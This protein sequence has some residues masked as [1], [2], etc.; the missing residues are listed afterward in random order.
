MSENDFDV[1]RQRAQDERDDLVLTGEEIELPG[2]DSD[3]SAIIGE[4]S[5]PI[6]TGEIESVAIGGLTGRVPAAAPLKPAIEDRISTG[7]LPVVPPVAG[8]TDASSDD[9]ETAAEAVREQADAPAPDSPADEP[10]SPAPTPSAESE[11]SE[12]P[13]PSVE[14]SADASGHA[15]A[16]ASDESPEP[17]PAGNAPAED[18]ETRATPGSP[19]SSAG[20]PVTEGSASPNEEPAAVEESPAEQ[21]SIEETAS[22]SAQEPSA[23]ASGARETPASPIETQSAPSD[24]SSPASR[25][26]ASEPTE[27]AVEPAGQAGKPAEQAGESTEQA[28]EPAEQA[29]DATTDASPTDVPFSSLDTST[30]EDDASTD[31][32]TEDA[33]HAGGAAA[34]DPGDAAPTHSPVM[35]PAQ[36]AAMLGLNLDAAQD[37]QAPKATTEA[38]STRP[39]ATPPDAQAPTEDAAGEIGGAA[40]THSLPSRRTIIF[41]DEPPAASIPPLASSPTETT[42]VRENAALRP[43]PAADTAATQ[44]ESTAGDAP[45][46]LTR[47]ADPLPARD[48][49]GS[50]DTAGADETTQLPTHPA[51]ASYSF[52][53][54]DAAEA[55]RPR[56]RSVLADGDREAATLAAIASAGRSGTN[57][58]GEARLDDELFSAAPQVTEMPSRTGAH[59]ISFLGFLLLTPVAWFLAADAGA[60]MTLADSAPMYTGIASFQA[61]G[62]LA[63]AVLVCVIL[64]ALARRSSLGAWIMGV[65]TLA[66]GLPWVLAPGVTASSLL[67]ALT[68]LSQTGPVGA[69]LMHHLQASGYSGRFVVVG[70]LLMG[71]AYV[72]HSA[73]RAGRAEEALRTSLETTNPAEAFYSKRARK[74]AAKDTGRK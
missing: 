29:E 39:E 23:P 73:R 34:E 12:E 37:R 65:L 54:Q 32:A 58:G 35:T 13:T 67:G 53:D 6:H 48:A 40:A 1:Q 72:S 70:A 31:E 10:D 62:E 63:G 41:G 8:A 50:P 36:A 5:A 14:A 11:P 2:E 15:E 25:R 3:A 30:R 69:N 7:E 16:D 52:E 26:E 17:E 56:R 33:G 49:A 21:A 18:A 47:D 28:G 66:A 38:P 44:E 27:K 45:A 20:S 22:L 55:A 43:Y 68:S 74:R 64:F 71:V 61:L 9:T 42:A 46:S 19:V 59:W 51:P 60:R 24:A 57:A 4:S